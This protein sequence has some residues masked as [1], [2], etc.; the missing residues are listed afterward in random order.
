MYV[1]FRRHRL[2]GFSLDVSDEKEHIMGEISPD[3]SI[4]VVKLGALYKG[5]I[6]PTIVMVL[7]ILMSVF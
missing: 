6:N 3:F 1:L 2:E 5:K 4:F 7:K